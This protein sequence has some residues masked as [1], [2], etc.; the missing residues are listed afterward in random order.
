MRF[1]HKVRQKSKM[2]KRK[3][4]L[5]NLRHRLCLFTDSQTMTM[6]NLHNFR[7]FQISRMNKKCLSTISLTQMLLMFKTVYLEALRL[8]KFPKSKMLCSR[9]IQ[10]KE[11]RQNHQKQCTLIQTQW[12]NLMSSNTLKLNNLSRNFRLSKKRSIIFTAKKLNQTQNRQK[13]REK[14]MMRKLKSLSLN[15]ISSLRFC[16]MKKKRFRLSS[17]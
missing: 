5:K 6:I 11:P 3:L 10:E 12:H 13:Q 8:F 2:V 17:R 7:C 9:Q 16:I 1:L 4:L 14:K 15:L